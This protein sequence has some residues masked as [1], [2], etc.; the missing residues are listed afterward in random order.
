MSDETPSTHLK[1]PLH[2]GLIA[3][4]LGEHADILASSQVDDMYGEMQRRIRRLR[5]DDEIEL[6]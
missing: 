4:H 6:G 3:G 1:R 5:G 2:Y